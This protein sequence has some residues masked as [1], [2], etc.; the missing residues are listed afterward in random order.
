MESKFHELWNLGP[1]KAA[2]FA[3]L[4]I[5]AVELCYIESLAVIYRVSR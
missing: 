2:N 1:Q 5:L 4:L 3:L